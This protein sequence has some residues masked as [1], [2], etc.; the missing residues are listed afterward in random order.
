MGR[1]LGLDGGGTKTDAVVVDST[2]HVLARQ[3]TD[4]LDPTL[5]IGWEAALSDIA[6]RLGPVTA[7][8]L[9]L[10]FHGEIA[11]LSARQTALAAALFGPGSRVVNDVAVAFEGASAGADG[12]LVLAGTGSMAWSRGPLGEHRVGGWGDA[13]GDE[14]SAYWIGRTALARISHQLDGRIAATGFADAMLTRLGIGGSDLIR[15]T[16]GL[17]NQRA[18]IAALAATVSN[19]ALQGS[20]DAKAIMTDAAQHLAELGLTAA[21]LCGEPHRWSFAGGAMSDATLMNVLTSAMGCTPTP[22]ELPPVGGAA[23]AAAKA[24]G[25]DIGPDFIARLKAELTE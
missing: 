22:P 19:L 8:V 2:G 11:D 6:K 9:G 16:Y 13:F 24:A 25:W 10:P 3:R 15:W 14:G 12:V 20:A 17:E 23:L 4:G 21:R 1:V 18:G 7:A 5:G